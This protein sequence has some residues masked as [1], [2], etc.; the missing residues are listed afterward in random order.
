MQTLTSSKNIGISKNVK[1][2][3]LTL[4][5]QHENIQP[6]Y[7]LDTLEK[8]SHYIFMSDSLIMKNSTR[9]NVKLIELLFKNWL[10][11]HEVNNHRF[12]KT[13]KI[14]LGEFQKNADNN[15]T[16]EMS[17]LNTF[18]RKFN[19]DGFQE[20]LYDMLAKDFTKMFA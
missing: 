3:V 1:Y 15:P 20:N 16:K 19:Y 9:T 18:K 10:D 12:I 13:I 14:T 11:N 17:E 4:K 8:Q 6:D 7:I 2:N 5:T